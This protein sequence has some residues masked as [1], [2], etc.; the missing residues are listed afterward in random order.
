M[1]NCF[2]ANYIRNRY[3]LVKTIHDQRYI[4][5]VA[6]IR[7]ARER[8]GKTQSE[9]AKILGRPQSYISKIETCERRI[10]VVELLQ[11]CRAIGVPLSEVLP[12]EFVD[13]I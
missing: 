5:V 11:L 7:R 10:D 6:L 9:I 2:R 1:R 4:E 13:T 8:S 12:T 3:V